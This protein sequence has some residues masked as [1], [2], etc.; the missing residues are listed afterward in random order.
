MNYMFLIRC[1]D[2]GHGWGN[3]GQHGW[4][5][6]DGKDREEALTKSKQM[7]PSGWIIKYRGR[8]NREPSL[9]TYM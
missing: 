6:Q 7:I 4:I 1:V 9:H 2:G 3:T 5:V 8:T